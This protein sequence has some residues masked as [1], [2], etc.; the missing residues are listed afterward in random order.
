MTAYGASVK[1][2][3]WIGYFT[4]YAELVENER[5]SQDISR[6]QVILLCGWLKISLAYTHQELADCTFS[7]F[8]FSPTVDEPLKRACESAA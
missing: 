7:A 8:R 1:T 6:T 3:T 2:A 5:Q 4:D